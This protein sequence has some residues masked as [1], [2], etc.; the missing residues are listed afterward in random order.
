M[1]DK[2]IDKNN[3]SRAVKEALK[4]HSIPRPGKIEIEPTKATETPE[5]LSLAYSPGVAFPSM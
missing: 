2:N 5:D 3:V 4:Y 1:N